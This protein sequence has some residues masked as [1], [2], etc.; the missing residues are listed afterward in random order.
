MHRFSLSHAQLIACVPCKVMHRFPIFS[1]AVN[2]MCFMKI[3]ASLPPFPCTV[4]H[5]LHATIGSLHLFH[6]IFSPLLHAQWCISSM[7]TLAHCIF[8]MR[9][10]ASVSPF[11]CEVMHLFPLFHAQWCI[12]SMQT[13]VNSICSMQS[14]VS[15]AHVGTCSFLHSVFVFGRRVMSGDSC[16]SWVM[17]CDLCQRSHGGSES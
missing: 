6:A 14:Y 17:S 2:T 4:M 3:Y 9:S 8:S 16:D 12:G 13:F 7:Q 15:S 5:F 10:Y 11:P 1:C